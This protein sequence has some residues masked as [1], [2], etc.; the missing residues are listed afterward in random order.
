MPYQITLALHNVLRW[1]VLLAG[2]WAV[3]RA[4]T[5]CLGKGGWLPADKKASRLFPIL[6]DVQTLA[7]L[8][9]YCGLSPMMRVAYGDM[10]TAMH[11]PELRFYLVW[12]IAGIVIALALAHV[13]KVRAM[14]LSDSVARHKSLFLWYGASLLLIVA[15]TPWHRPLLPG[16]H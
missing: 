16:L 8:A 1:A 10:P 11:V 2:L 15:R 12:H 13:G 14:R 3:F 5:G 7:G 9:L 6:L 4:F